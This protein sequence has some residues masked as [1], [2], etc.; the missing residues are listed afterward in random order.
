MVQLLY[1]LAIPTFGY[2]LVRS[3]LTRS[4]APAAAS[5][6]VEHAAEAASLA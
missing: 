3:F 5:A 2:Q 4:R 1:A 6:N